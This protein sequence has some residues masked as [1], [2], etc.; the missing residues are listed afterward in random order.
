MLQRDCEDSYT[1]LSWSVPIPGVSGNLLTNLTGD[2]ADL[3][4][5]NC[6]YEPQYKH[7]ADL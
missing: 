3:Q 6:N 2:R 7:N 1:K 4:V 5:W